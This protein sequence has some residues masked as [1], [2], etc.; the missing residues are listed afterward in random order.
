LASK[1]YDDIDWDPP[2]HLSD[3]GFDP[4]Q[5]VFNGLIV[6]LSIVIAVLLIAAKW[7]RQLL[8]GWTPIPE[9]EATHLARK[10]DGTV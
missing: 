2:D 6:G 9:V 4:P 5:F 1:G 10:Y 3:V 8:E 7:R